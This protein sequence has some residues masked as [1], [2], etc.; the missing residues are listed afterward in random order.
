MLPQPGHSEAVWARENSE[1]SFE[2]PG[3]PTGSR[4]DWMSYTSVELRG[5]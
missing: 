3:G 4:E 2:D 5:G 1:L